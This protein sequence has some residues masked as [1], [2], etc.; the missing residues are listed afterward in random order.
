MVLVNSIENLDEILLEVVSEIVEVG[1]HVLAREASC[2][3]PVLN[4]SVE[5]QGDDI[6]RT[7]LDTGQSVGEAEH[8]LLNLIAQAAAAGQGVRIVGEVGEEGVAL[9]IHL[10]GEGLVVLVHHVFAV[11]Q[12]G[13]CL[14]G[15]GQH[16]LGTLSVEP[17]DEVLL[18]EVNPLPYGLAPVGEAEIVE[19]GVP[20]VLVVVRHVGEGRLVAAV[21]GRLVDAVN[22]LLV[23]LVNN[24]AY[25]SFWLDGCD[26]A[27]VQMVLGAEIL[28]TVIV[29]HIEELTEGN[30]TLALRRKQE[31]KVAEL[32]A[33]R[34]EVLGSGGSEPVEPGCTFE[35]EGIQRH[36]LAVVLDCRRRS[37]VV[38]VDGMVVD[39][40]LVLL[41]DLGEHLLEFLLHAVALN[42]TIDGL[43]NLAV[44]IGHVLDCHIGV[45]IGLGGRC[46][47]GIRAGIG[48]HIINPLLDEAQVLVLL[49][50]QDVRLG[51][52]EVLLVHQL[53]L[54]HILN[55]LDLEDGLV[56]K[57]LEKML[58]A[59]QKLL[60]GRLFT[61]CH[62]SG[63]NRFL[64]FAEIV[65]LDFAVPL[66]DLHYC[67]WILDSEVIQT[68]AVWTKRVFNIG[69]IV[70][71]NPPQGPIQGI[72]GIAGQHNGC[73]RPVR[74][75]R[76]L[77]IH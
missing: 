20:V 49:A 62:K 33:E 46:G 59:A 77:P 8:V 68:F 65:S 41:G 28:G 7:C 12:Q 18:E 3:G 69:Q 55:L 24:L 6:R 64:D 48:V 27:C 19:Q 29:E 39:V 52:V 15:E 42:L 9:G 21:P 67:F 1:N 53:L 11:G 36:G 26:V 47:I 23:E 4:N 14:H 66:Y 17:A 10:G 35:D 71:H 43:V 51:N 34:A 50:I 32:P 58:E 2:L 76:V 5:V 45:G 75:A 63:S 72:F 61:V 25:G 70:I 13:H 22:Y 30:G 54:D 73:R 37:L 56:V 60:R 44:E 40:G 31:G 57:H 38:D 74:S 16:S